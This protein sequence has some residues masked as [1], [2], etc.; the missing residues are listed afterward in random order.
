M[1]NIL[2]NPYKSI[3]IEDKN[4]DILVAR[5]GDKIEFI[6]ESTGEVIKGVVT[7]FASKDEKLKIQIFNAD[8]NC[9]EIWSVILIKEGTLK[10][11]EETEDENENNE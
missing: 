4:G 3:E 8:K 10:L 7:K 2:A 9:E 6:L 5:E 1:L 11:I